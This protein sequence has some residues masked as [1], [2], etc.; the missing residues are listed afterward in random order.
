VHEGKPESA[1]AA[2]Q[3]SCR[4]APFRRDHV[5]EVCHGDDF[6]L[7]FFPVFLLAFYLDL[8]R[9]YA[10]ASIREIAALSRE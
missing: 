5:S 9:K 2:A 7:A 4:S 10:A 1:F 3:A 6:L 8:A